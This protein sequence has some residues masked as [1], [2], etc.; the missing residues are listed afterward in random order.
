M[1][2]VSEFGVGDEQFGGAAILFHATM[3]RFIRH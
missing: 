1:N 3:T 2:F